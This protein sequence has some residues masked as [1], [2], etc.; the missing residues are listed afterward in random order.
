M[1][2]GRIDARGAPRRSRERLRLSGESLVSAARIADVAP[3]Q[4]SS[5]QECGRQYGEGRNVSLRNS[6]QITAEHMGHG[7]E[8]STD[9]YPEERHRQAIRSDEQTC[10]QQN[11]AKADLEGA[12]VLQEVLVIWLESGEHLKERIWVDHRPCPKQHESGTAAD[13]DDTGHRIDH[14]RTISAHIESCHWIRAS[15]LVAPVRLGISLADIYAEPRPRSSA[16]LRQHD[17]TIRA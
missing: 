2:R 12:D 6:A 7:V 15:R 3:P 13:R 5:R 10:E 16:W 17:P 9:T 1:S 11:H 14:G 8:R 4:P